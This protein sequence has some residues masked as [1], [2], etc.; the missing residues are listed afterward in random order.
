M[1][2][3]LIALLFLYLPLTV[4]SQTITVE[5]Y[6][7]FAD[8]NGLSLG[9][10]TLT[11]TDYGLLIVANLSTLPAGDG[12]IPVRLGFHIHQNA[13]CGDNGMAAG[14]HLDPENTNSH[15]GPMGNGHLGDLRT[16]IVNSDGT[17]SEA[18]INSR[19]SVADVLNHS[20][21]IHEGGDNY[22]DTPN[23]L[24]GGGPRY[25]CG[26]IEAPELVELEEELL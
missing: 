1:T 22:S 16:L 21:M 18:Q 10:V 15:Q 6:P 19:L 26:V 5:M 2:K 17:A 4:F 24:G 23:P 8:N 12:D 13:D 14:G 20:I 25:A 7:V 3:K 9:T 11:D